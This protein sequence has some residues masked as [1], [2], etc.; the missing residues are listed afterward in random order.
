[1][2]LH[3]AALPA[4]ELRP[5]S[6]GEVLGLTFDLYRRNLPLFIGIAALVAVPTLIILSISQLM[7]ISVFASDPQ[8]YLN[9]FG[10][11]GASSTS[12]GL[13]DSARML[14]LGANCILFFAYI[15][16]IF[17]P[18]MEGALT[19]N[20]IER[21]LGRSP[22]LRESYHETR[23]RF[24][25]L[26][27]SNALMMLALGVLWFFVIAFVSVPI[28]VGISAAS[29]PPT[30]TSGTGGIVT[31]VLGLLCLPAAL[32]GAIFAIVLALNWL[33]RAQVIAGEG[34]DGT[35]ALGRSQELVKGYRLRLFG[36]YL[37]MA[38]LL[39]LCTVI[40]FLILTGIISSASMSSLI[41]LTPASPTFARA[42]VPLVTGITVI[43]LGISFIA[44]LL[45]TPLRVIF[46]TVNYL[47]VRIRKENL[48]A[49]ILNMQA[50]AT[51][52]TAVVVP[53][54]EASRPP[55]LVTPAP[56]SA[57]APAPAPAPVMLPPTPS[58]APPPA[59]ISASSVPPSALPAFTTDSAESL[60]PGQ[61]IGVLF[62]R[63]KAEGASAQ[64]LNDLG[65]AY[66][67][68]GDTSGA[69]D[70]L[71]RAR[72]LDPSDADVAFNL[73]QVYRSRKDI[74]QAKQLMA[75]YL[76]LER[77]PAELAA[78]RNN[79]RYKDLIE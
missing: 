66:M 33:F 55:S 32:A 63:I 43:S 23:A 49:A 72:T 3:T 6:T 68:I 74:H 28:G 9:R 34:L 51:G 39:G 47:D 18:W 76:R 79:P 19:H 75:E 15:A 45:F 48:A 21:A 24:G 13:S 8:A 16:G 27:G 36:R 35:G 29:G 1:M 37:L 14:S 57:P 5:R 40:P 65:L 61:R 20:V 38:L 46:N 26:W 22:G 60:P 59:P 53:P 77:N 30:D 64:L 11:L 10:A 54:A 7:S 73:A 52:T 62:N 44:T 69:L 50:A 31:A 78:V 4:V 2:T 56:M 17:W 71:T 70:A 25:A 12:A 41:N 42:L 67:E 58:A